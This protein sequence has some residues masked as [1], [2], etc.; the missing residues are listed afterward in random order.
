MFSSQKPATK[1]ISIP[2]IERV[3]A[4][5]T[6]ARPKDMAVS[7]TFETQE[8]DNTCLALAGVG[9]KTAAAYVGGTTGAAAVLG[10][11][12]VQKIGELFQGAQPDTYYTR[13][14][15]YLSEPDLQPKAG[16][17]EHR[18]ITDS[19][20]GLYHICLEYQSSKASR[21]GFLWFGE[22]K[23]NDCIDDPKYLINILIARKIKA[24][25]EADNYQD[26]EKH[27]QHLTEFLGKI[28]A[29]DNEDLLSTRSNDT[30]YLSLITLITQVTYQLTSNSLDNTAKNNTEKLAKLIEDAR[31]ISTQISD[32][33]AS[34]NTR[35]THLLSEGEPNH[36][37]LYVEQ[38]KKGQPLIGRLTSLTQIGDSPYLKWI[39]AVLYGN[40]D[41]LDFKLLRSGFKE[42]TNIELSKDAAQALADILIAKKRLTDLLTAF[43][44]LIRVIHG[45]HSAF[46]N[47]LNDYVNWLKQV[48]EAQIQLELKQFKFASLLMTGFSSFTDQC[49]RYQFTRYGFAESTRKDELITN[50]VIDATCLAL[51]EVK[52]EVEQKESDAIGLFQKALGNEYSHVTGLLPQQFMPAIE[53]EKME[54]VEIEEMMNTS[55]ILVDGGD[56]EDTVVGEEVSLRE[57]IKRLQEM[58]STPREIIQEQEKRIKEKDAVIEQ[59]QTQ[60]QEQ[61][62]EL[63]DKDAEIQRLKDAAAEE[64]R[65]RK[66]RNENRKYFAEISHGF[67][68]L[69]ESYCDQ[70]GCGGFFHGN[71]VGA[72]RFQKLFQDKMYDLFKSNN[73]LVGLSDVL[74]AFIALINEHDDK[75]LN[76]NYYGGSLKCY[77][78][79]FYVSQTHQ[80]HFVAGNDA[81]A[82]TPLEAYEHCK[83]MF[84]WDIKETYQ[85]MK[86]KQA[87]QIQLA[88]GG[89]QAHHQSVVYFNKA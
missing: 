72:R 36:F 13:Q 70:D 44:D 16:M 10:I 46:A 55:W 48:K 56:V 22:H 28:C 61:Q 65:K 77:L 82:F 25:A 1:V 86:T 34:I 85:K 51:T 87:V 67:D 45:N 23:Q 63:H 26:Y 83:E 62:Q 15:E 57:K 35:L 58:A 89:V 20:Q 6:D 74:D 38:V 2:A 31:F 7:I 71:R 19:L 8:D 30:T 21:P 60:I 39:S 81:K 69:M 76:G 79:A 54:T 17:A 88:A 59:Q 43:D 33:V 9:A 75:L 84:F 12:F 11:E 47:I 27:R 68:Q 52:Q 37:K 24:A 41:K 3:L 4:A 5:Y 32:S 80:N 64:S 40:S 66:I 14:L 53:K 78:L 42:Y 50:A 29:A 18:K 49:Y 73:Q